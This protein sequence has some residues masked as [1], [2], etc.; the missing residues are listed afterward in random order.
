MF[1]IS[2]EL[3]TKSIKRLYYNIVN[4][5]FFIFMFINQIKINK[6]W[7]ECLLQWPYL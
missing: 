7:K 1:D 4:R 3:S 2:I 5:F 6:L